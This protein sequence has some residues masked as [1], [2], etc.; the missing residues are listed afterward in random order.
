MIIGVQKRTVM[1]WAA[2]YDDLPS[3]ENDI[4]K[5]GNDDTENPNFELAS[6]E[7]SGSSSDDGDDNSENYADDIGKSTIASPSGLQFG[8]STKKNAPHN[9]IRR[10][11]RLPT[12]QMAATPI[13]VL[14][15]NSSYYTRNCELLKLI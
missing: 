15:C 13:E 3:G 6:G 9:T 11:L 2:E 7:Y 1:E 10:A 8:A 14:I 12:N 4:S 5:A